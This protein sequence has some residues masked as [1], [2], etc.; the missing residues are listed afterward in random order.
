MSERRTGE[1]EGKESLSGREK[2]IL[3]LLGLPTFGLALGIGTVT[4]YGPLLARRFTSS[5]AVIGLVIAAEGLVALVVPLA[6]GAWSDQL[7]TR[8]GG[9]LPFLLAGAPAVGI[10]VALM[11][12]VQSLA[13][14]ALLV[15]TFFVAYYA[16]YEP[17]RALYPDLLSAE[18]AGRGQ[19]TQAIFR[20]LATATALTAGGLLFG[21][22]PKLPFLIFAVI[23]FAAI[24]G[25]GWGIRGSRAVREQHTH[26]ARTVGETVSRLS[27]LVRD[28]HALKA[29]LFANA[30]WELSLAALKTFVMLFLTA[31]V[32]LSMSSAVG[33][34]AIVL[35]LVL[36]AAPVSGK[37]G[38]RYGRTRV[39]TVS[40][41]LFGIG[42]L[43]PFFT[44]SP[45]LVMPILPF[46]AFGGGMVLTLPYA[47]LMPLM[48][49]EEHGLITGFY[50]FSRGLGILLGPTLA[51]LAITAMRPVLSSTDGYAAMWLVCGVA[52]L[53][54]LVF[55]APLRAKEKQLRRERDRER[56][57]GR[58]SAQSA[59]A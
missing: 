10:A 27:K 23:A 9:R 21:L 43:V 39:V 6:A 18:V 37:L 58:R 20:G 55:M 26:E 59:T 57:S 36:I 48:P 50:S 13:L 54:S 51:G 22:S 25:F 19:S 17:Y 30:L 8:L 47:I 16:A 15:F 24:A 31:G 32:R 44:Q 11:G 14:L 56:S 45:Y 3:A 1:G 2:R 40:L 38:D 53:V 35:V 29:F 34:I 42:L 5:S 41:W 4:T 49:D 7:K 28:R 12:F 52:I 46:V 33:V